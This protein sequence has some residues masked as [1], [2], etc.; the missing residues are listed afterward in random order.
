MINGYR[1]CIASSEIVF[2][3]RYICTAIDG[4]DVLGFYPKQTQELQLMER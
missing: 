2:A 4:D 3:L 1:N